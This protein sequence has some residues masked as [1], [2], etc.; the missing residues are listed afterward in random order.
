MGRD[1]LQEGRDDAVSNRRYT[2][3]RA[4]EECHSKLP[5]VYVCTYVRMYY[6]RMYYVRMYVCTMYVRMYVRICTVLC[7]CMYV[8]TYVCNFMK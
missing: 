8:C 1:E 4:A 6:V 5:V 7:T 2:E 3:Y